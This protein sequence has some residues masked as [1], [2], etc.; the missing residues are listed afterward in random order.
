MSESE[1]SRFLTGNED[2]VSSNVTGDGS[3]D[4]RREK[5]TKRKTNDKDGCYAMN[6]NKGYL[7]KIFVCGYQPIF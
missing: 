3:E 6:I 4:T 5:R 2:L 1:S 7:T